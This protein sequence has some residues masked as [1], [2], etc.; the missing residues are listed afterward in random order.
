MGVNG[1]CLKI[2]SAKLF[3]QSCTPENSNSSLSLAIFKTE[4][5]GEK[6]NSAFIG[7]PLSASENQIGHYAKAKL[8]SIS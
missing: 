5:V 2:Q 1:K 7:C 4:K 6:I 8:F 3:L